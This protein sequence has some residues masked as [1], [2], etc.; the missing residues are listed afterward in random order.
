VPWPVEARQN[1][2]SAR[3]ERGNGDVAGRTTIG[4]PV[5]VSAARTVVETDRA[6]SEM[7][8]LKQS[9]RD[10]E[11]FEELDHYRLIGEVAV[12][13]DRSDHAPDR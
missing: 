2:A 12:K 3:F 1:R 8:D 5:D 7:H 9:A 6:R 10:H 11:V 13:E 4:L